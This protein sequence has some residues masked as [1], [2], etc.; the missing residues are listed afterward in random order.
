MRPSPRHPKLITV[1]LA[2]IVLVFFAD[3]LAVSAA[4]DPLP[5]NTTGAVLAP[6]SPS[7]ISRPYTHSALSLS[8]RLLDQAGQP[9]PNAR[10]DI[11]QEVADSS[12][13]Q[14]IGSVLTRTDGSLTANIPAGP[15]RLIDLAYP[16]SE[17]GAY[18]TQTEVFES[19]T[20]GLQLRVTP[21]RT[22][23]TG[24]VQL[25]GHVLGVIPTQGVVVE[26]LVYYLGEW[27]PIRTPRTTPD[28]Q[29][30][31]SYRFHKARGQFPFRLRVRYGQTGF[32]YGE[33]CSRWVE[34][35]A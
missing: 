28:G 31:L 12:H 34:V 5:T 3:I 7:S 27:Q 22:T 26:V 35:L 9:I 8:T 15:S 4:A 16:A 30:R 19:V 20:A 23:P 6:I 29:L 21:R 2:A 32:P 18:V 17:G 14:L 25:E 33:A 10:V 1:L 24:T 13:M 11:L